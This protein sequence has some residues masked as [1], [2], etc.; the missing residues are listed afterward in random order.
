MEKLKWSTNFLIDRIMETLQQLLKK[1]VVS[2]E[3]TLQYY[4]LWVE[5]IE[6]GMRGV[7]LKIT[8]I[9]VPELNIAINMGNSKVNVFDCDEFHAV[10]RYDTKRTILATLGYPPK[11]LKTVTIRTSSTVGK[12]L[13]WLEEVL[14]TKKEKEATLIPLFEN[15]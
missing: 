15:L 2:E 3:L 5:G 4:E 8:E 1:K 6:A 10:I 7:F 11:F 9:Y 14:R 13:V 12:N